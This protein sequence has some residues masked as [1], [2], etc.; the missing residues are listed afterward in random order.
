M[1]RSRFGPLLFGLAL[2][3]VVLGLRLFQIQVLE[4]AVWAE[5]AARMLHG[6][7]E[8][9]Y[10]RGRILDAEERVLASDED[11]RSV[12]LYYRSF[13]REHPLAQVA[14]ARS[15]L[16]GRPLS[17]VDARDHLVEWARELVS[18]RAAD[19][20]AFARGERPGSSSPADPALRLRR[21]ADLSF[22]LRQLLGFRG[23]EDDAL[24]KAL[25]ER[26]RLEP[27]RSFLELA[28]A[29]RRGVTP[30]ALEEEGQA[31]EDRLAE[32]MGV[33]ERLAGWLRPEPRPGT[34]P[35]DELL[36]EL[37]ATRRA[38]EDAAA[39]KLFAEATGFV[40]GR[41][42]TDTLL[43]CF[44]HTWLADLLCWDSTRLAEW[45][46]TVRQGWLAGWRDGVCVPRVLW[47]L[48]DD[49]G[50][51]RGPGQFLDCL[52]VVFEPEEALEASMDAG[53]TP[54]REVRELAVF[55]QL[56][57][58]FAAGVPASAER[59]AADALPILLEEL[60]AQPDDLELF[61]PDLGPDSFRARLEQALT[62]R[63]RPDVARLTELAAELLP[64]WDLRFQETLRRALDD[65]RREARDDEL[66]PQGGLVLA[67]GGRERAAERA[68]YFLRDYGTRPRLLSGSD[69]TWDVV[70]LLT[71]KELELPGFRVGE[72]RARDVLE[73]PGDD[74][75][76]A[77]GLLGRV[78]APTLDDLQRQWRESAAL[79]RLQS[80]PERDRA[81]DEDLR[82][83]IGEVRLSNEVQGVSGLEAFFEPELAGVNG[84]RETRGL[85]DVFGAGAEELPVREPEDGEDVV[86]TLDIDLQAAAQRCLRHPAQGDGN[87]DEDW[88][89]NPVGAIVLL[90]RA[91]EVLA[92]ASEPD[93]ESEIDENASAARQQ[94][95]ERTLKKPWFQPPGS[96]FKV[97]VAAWA[98]DHGLDPEHEVVCGPIAGG[99]S[100]YK[101]LRCWNTVGHGP[102]RLEQ[103]IER[104]CNAY[105]AWLGETMRTE[106]F[107]ELC[108]VF[109]FGQPTGVRR[110]PPWDAGRARRTGLSEDL[111]GL[112]AAP[113]EE[114]PDSLRSM[115]ANG[116][117]RIEATPMQVARAMLAL[118]T[119]EQRELTLVKRVGARP[120]PLGT[121]TPLPISKRSLD[122]V[123]GAMLEVARAPLGTAHAALGPTALGLPIAVK[124]GSADVQSRKDDQGHSQVVK[125]AWVAGWLPPERPELVF[126]LFEGRTT[127]TSS[128]G[129]I[130]VA[131]QLLTQ[132][133]VLDWLGARG[134]DVS[135][136]AAR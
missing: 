62:G 95:I 117:G 46:T 107:R 69:L 136:V 11:Q 118:G 101:S 123:R 96:P 44:D 113:G 98:L 28:A 129:A 134:V 128:H 53:P 102:L 89:A 25:R 27:E 1:I 35:L 13:R 108:D 120:Y 54:W 52:A 5:E 43:E 88:R 36:A 49:P 30:R 91:G 99:G 56:D 34:T 79:R 97:F 132:P 127:A 42:E 82:R 31:L 93:D 29:V 75:R 126:V 125:H 81:E 41:I 133:E 48:V 26:A 65:I 38:V 50:A 90:S 100:G 115:A 105:F 4:H 58:L 116:L 2:L 9:P 55:A 39:A 15:L 14:H 119:G 72:L 21:A 32:S 6:G 109:G 130:Y 112:A 74:V 110:A 70:Y 106:D 67:E 64:Q 103:A 33:L 135:Q 3:G 17:L 37:E 7:R 8:V 121:P 23:R 18:L 20:A 68:E 73:Q 80:Q 63:S 24:W 12:E 66:G 94:R 78:S 87:A 19:A 61:P 86:L 40:P 59:A 45:A 71:R 10:R 85:A 22:Y 57:S 16:L 111:A 114:L 77:L 104:S 60:R 76:P 92:A 124:T 51:E 131:R 47:N 84:Y 83:L 122:F